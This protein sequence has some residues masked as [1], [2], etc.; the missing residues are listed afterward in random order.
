MYAYN[1][2]VRV[3]VCAVST[4]ASNLLF[5]FIRRR[6]ASM[7]SNLS[8]PS[9]SFSAQWRSFF[10]DSFVGWLFVR[11]SVHSS[12]RGHHRPT[13]VQHR[14]AVVKTSRRHYLDSEVRIC[15]AETAK[16]EDFTLFRLRVVLDTHLPPRLQHSLDKTINRIVPR[17]INLCSSRSSAQLTAG[18]FSHFSQCNPSSPCNI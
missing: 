11:L 17:F 7:I 6:F 9:L 15:L 2:S 5:E 12:T 14:L 10:C 16:K 3:C 1:T 18:G 8:L 13:R 4:L